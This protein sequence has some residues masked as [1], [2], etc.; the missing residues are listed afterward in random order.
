MIKA[1]H[2][3]TCTFE[4][5]QV[6]SHVAPKGIKKVDQLVGR[7]RKPSPLYLAVRFL[8]RPLVTHPCLPPPC[9]SL[10]CST[11]LRGRMELTPLVPSDDITPILLRSL[12]G[13]R[14]TQDKTCEL[15]PLVTW[16]DLE[17]P[18]QERASEQSSIESPLPD[19][20]LDY[21]WEGT[22]S[23]KGSSY[24]ESSTDV[25]LE[26]QVRPCAVT[27]YLPP[28]L[29]PQALTAKLALLDLRVSTASWPMKCQHH[30]SL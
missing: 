6:P 28:P 18:A 9:L 3:S 27:H 26:P 30:T 10:V 8:V 22:Q 17:D 2:S 15:L 25:N 23:M 12:E 14:D 4:W 11:G 21:L 29:L 7:G 20:D 1:L 16:P 13:A 19:P 5:V 24:D